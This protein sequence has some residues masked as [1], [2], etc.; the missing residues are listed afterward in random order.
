LAVFPGASDTADVWA[1]NSTGATATYEVSID[2]GTTWELGGDILQAFDVLGTPV[3]AVPEPSTALL[4][5]TGLV[6]LLALARKS[7]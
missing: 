1:F 7:I 2:G 4:L 6:G 3:S 5:I